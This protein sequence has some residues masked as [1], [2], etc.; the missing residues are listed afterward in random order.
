MTTNAN[1]PEVLKQFFDSMNK[2][3][4][5]NLI[6]LR[7][8]APGSERRAKTALEKIY[9][10]FLT[11]K[12]RK[13][14]KLASLDVGEPP[15]YDKD[16]EVIVNQ[17]IQDK[18]GIIETQRTDPNARKFIERFRYHLKYQGQVWRIDRK[19]MFSLEKSKWINIV[20]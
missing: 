16:L 17:D 7:T 4:R 14:G 6:P 9:S 2:W 3:E 19:E 15:E 5:D 18:T 10:K 13:S 8:E 11:K 1:A 12:E 20:L